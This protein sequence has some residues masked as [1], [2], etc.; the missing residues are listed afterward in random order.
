MKN[1]SERQAGMLLMVIASIL[2]TVVVSF[3]ILLVH[4]GW[5]KDILLLWYPDLLLGCGLSILTAFIIIPPI[6]SRIDRRI[7]K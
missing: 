4:V 3:G 2:I 7:K 1:L 5:R 6:K